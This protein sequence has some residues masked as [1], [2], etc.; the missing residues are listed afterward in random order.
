ML[1]NSH[2]EKCLPNEV[3]GNGRSGMCRDESDA[4]SLLGHC[5]HLYYDGY[6]NRCTE[7]STLQFF[8]ADNTT[9]MTAIY[10]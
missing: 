2:V 5:H 10:G 4:C 8:D 9:A 3:Y 6:W 1:S 7:A